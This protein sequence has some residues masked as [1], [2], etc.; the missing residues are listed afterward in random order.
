[1]I[2]EALSQLATIIG[3]PLAILALA[4]TG[5]QLERT[6]LLERGRF[7]LELERMSADH[8]KTHLRLR[9]S[10]DLADGHTPP[11]TP[12]EWAELEDYMG[13]F[14]HC[15]LLID[16][17]ALDQSSFERLFG[18]R[19]RNILSNEAIVKIKLVR[20]GKHWED[21]RKLAERLG[22]QL[23]PAAS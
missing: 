17:G 22:C 2:L 7:L 3:A 19:V 1:M 13:F 16:A 21:F 5:I 11:S 15:E 9:P 10:G 4:F 20:E 6:L 14:E 23:P 8:A 18:Y 12:A